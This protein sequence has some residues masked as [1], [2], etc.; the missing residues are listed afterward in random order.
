VLG[1]NEDKNLLHARALAEA[2]GA[3]GAEW[4]LTTFGAPLTSES[5]KELARYAAMFSEAGAK[6]AAEFS[7]LGKVTSI[8]AALAVVEAAGA[9]RAGVMIDTWHFF[10]GDSTW[11][12][13]ETVPLER[14]AYV[15][16][17]DALEPVS[18][19]AMDE[20]MNRRTMP[21]DGSFALERFVSTLLGRGWDGL[22]SLEVL[23]AELRRLPVPEFARTAHESAIRYW[24]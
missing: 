21:G 17:D 16:F 24:R 12:D 5:A 2:A 19:D 1:R 4:V 8:P 23:S 14:I 18:D 3:V 20:T 10:R 13:L 9:A 22:V 11:E 7:P 6:M 15:Q